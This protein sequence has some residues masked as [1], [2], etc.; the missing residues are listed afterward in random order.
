VNLSGL[1]NDLCID[2]ETR[3]E[4]SKEARDAQTTLDIQTTKLETALLDTIKLFIGD[5]LPWLSESE[6]GE[7]K[8]QGLRAVLTLLDNGEEGAW[9]MRARWGWYREFVRRVS[10][11]R[12]YRMPRSAY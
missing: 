5:L 12:Q 11:A 1:E 3:L 9:S 4:H 7:T 2:L 6:G 8:G 10:L